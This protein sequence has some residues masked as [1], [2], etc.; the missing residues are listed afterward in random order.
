M[1]H[2]YSHWAIAAGLLCAA[3]FSQAAI[4][5]YSAVLSGPNESP[6]NSSPATGWA[7]VTIDDLLHTLRVEASFS[8][9]LGNSTVAHIHCCTSTALTGTVGVA[10]TTPTFPGFP[11]GVTS[12]SYDALFLLTDAGSFNPAF[13]SNNGGTPASAEVALLAGLAAN[14]AYFNLHTSQFPGGEIR[15]FLQ[16]VPEPSTI[17]LL[18]LGLLGLG[19]SRRATH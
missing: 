8:G 17:A 18:G 6:P 13:V 5:Q 4:I 14:R 12:G 1:K 9:L 2:R 3:P 16:Q 15:G 7:R 11:S 19:L 10:S